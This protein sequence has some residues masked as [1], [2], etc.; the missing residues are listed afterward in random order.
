MMSLESMESM[1]CTLGLSKT[2][3]AK[4]WEREKRA[5][6]NPGHRETLTYDLNSPA[7][8]RSR[9]AQTTGTHI[10]KQTHVV[11]QKPKSEL[12]GSLWQTLRADVFKPKEIPRS[13]SLTTIRPPL[14]PAPSKNCRS[15]M[16]NPRAA[17]KV[18]PQKDIFQE[19]CATELFREDTPNLSKLRLYF[20]GLSLKPEQINLENPETKWTFLHHFAYQGDVDLVKWCLE[21]GG[22]IMAKTAMGKTPLHLA[23]ENNKPCAAIALLKGGADPNA[24]TLSGYTSLHLA[25]LNG[26]GGVV[27]TL[28]ENSLVPLDVDADS[29]HGTACN[30]TR[31][32]AIRAKLEEYSANEFDGFFNSETKS[33]PPKQERIL[34]DS[35]SQSGLPVQSAWKLVKSRMIDL[36]STQ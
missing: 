23:V 13:K 30:L 12:N 25:A 26:H 28:L 17:A 19:V 16:H 34:M 18:R 22:D 7:R 10:L 29:A 20:K 9:F 31:D 33:D 32:P 8:S 1:R 21:A 14:Q 27:C 6:S 15:T 11:S 3:G 4:P 36:K 35:V 2:H 24:K 5:S